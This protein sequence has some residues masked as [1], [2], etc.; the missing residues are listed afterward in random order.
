MYVEQRVII[1]YLRFK[2]RTAKDIADE[3]HEM[4][5]QEISNLRLVQH[6][7]HELACGRTIPPNIP[8]KMRKPWKILFVQS[9]MP[10]RSMQE[11]C[12]LF[13][14]RTDRGKQRDEKIM[15]GTNAQPPKYLDQ[16]RT[17]FLELDY[18]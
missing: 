14:P 2:G 3:F 18:R 15:F 11:R 6:W 1:K 5:R 4:S 16:K 7:M 13:D 12:K 8:V 9:E 17:M 10:L